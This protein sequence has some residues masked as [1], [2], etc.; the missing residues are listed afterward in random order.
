MQEPAPSVYFIDFGESSLNFDL[1]VWT[2]DMT[3]SPRRLSSEL[4]F[5]I[6]KK[7]REK[8]KSRFRFHSAICICAPGNSSRRGAVMGTLNSGGL[9]GHNLR[10][11]SGDG[12]H[13]HSCMFKTRFL[14]S[15]V[16]CLLSI[17][18]R[19]I[20]SP[21]GDRLRLTRKIRARGQ[22]RFHHRPRIQNRSRSHRPGQ[23]QRKIIR[24]LDAAGR[25]QNLP[26]RRQH[27]RSEKKAV[28]KDARSSSMC[29]P[30]TKTAPKRPS[31]DP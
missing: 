31:R 8:T 19:S 5:A 17:P 4:F 29:P 11:A 12:S 7:L 27:A 24:V 26:R 23:S 22:R 13:N 16:C 20:F 14:T 1:G 6:E 10:L 28:R 25:Q 9:R 2:Q 3:H 15:S 18:D 30:L 21:T